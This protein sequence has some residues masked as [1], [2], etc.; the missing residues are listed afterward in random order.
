MKKI[1]IFLTLIFIFTSI[2]HFTSNAQVVNGF[3]PIQELGMPGDE[4]IGSISLSEANLFEKDFNSKYLFPM[5]GI[6][7][8]GNGKIAV[9][10]NSYGR[11]H[12]LNSILENELTFS[13]IKELTYPTDIAFYEGNL[14]ITDPLRNSVAIFNQYGK[15]IKSFGTATFTS[16]I[17]IAVS[18]DGIF[19]SDYFGEKL[20]KL[21]SKYAV[22]KT[23]KIDYPGGLAERNGKIYAV[24]MSKHS[25]YV[26]DKNLNLLSTISNDNMYFPSDV[27]V[28]NA[29]NVYV[30]DRGLLKGKDSSGKVLKFSPN[31]KFLFTIG[32]PAKIYPG[33]KNG[34]LL[35]PCGI[36]VQGENVFVMDG[37]HY[38]WDSNSD[39]PFGSPIGERLSVFSSTSIFLS[40][41]DFSQQTQGRLM[42]PISSTLDKNG[43]IWTVNYG[44]MKDSEIVEF[45]QSGDFIKRIKK[46]G[47]I[48]LSYMDCVYSDKNGHI[49]IGG[50]GFIIVLN[51]SGKLT[52]SINGLKSGEIRKIIKGN[53]GYFYA[54]LFQKN[55]VLQFSMDGTVKKFIPVCNLPSGICES[56][57][58]IFYITSIDDNK[59]HVYND[60][61][62]EIRTI[63][64]GGGRGKMNFYV[65][66]DVAM[67]KYGNII[68]ADAENGRL[69]VFR[70]NGTLL[71]Q[72]PRVFYEIASIEVEDG[73]LVVSDCF[74]NMVRILKENTSEKQ[75]LFLASVYPSS[76][77]VSPGGEADLD[78]NIVN[79]G[80]KSDNYNI[81]I[82]KNISPQWTII[83]EKGSVFLDSDTETKV[84]VIVKAPNNAKN[85]DSITLNITIS[86]PRE[87]ITLNA[88]I[89]VST[90]LPPVISIRSSSV[91]L[92]RE[93]TIP[94]YVNG[95]K[96]ATGITFTMHIPDGLKL[97]N[98]ENGSLINNSLTLSNI[99]GDTAI[100]AIAEKGEQS[101]SG[102]GI[103]A[104]A[105]FKG[106]KI[107]KDVI[108]FTDAYYENIVGGKLNFEIKSGEITIAPYLFVN[109]SDGI[110]NTS[111]NFTF[112]GKTT[113][114]VKL[115][116]N[117][118]TVK[119][120][121]DGTFTST[122][123]LNSLQNV[124]IISARSSSG[125]E[126]VIKRTVFYRGK[127]NI[128]IKLQ[129]GNPTMTVNGV[130]M[131][132]DPGRGTKPFIING[133]NRTVVPI[134]AIIEAIGGDIGWEPKDR[135]VWIIL[136][137][138][139]INMWINN[140][141]AKVN[142][143]PVWIDPSNH[144]VSPIIA[145]NRTFI[146]VRFVA[147]SLGCDVYWDATTKTVTIIYRR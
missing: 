67:D 74:H 118:Q 58:N 57:K 65:P 9:I 38:Y 100:F 11:I 109:F 78:I 79:E 139:T 45:S 34:A 50:D 27:D 14:Y 119:I 72:S 82:E 28:D 124:I 63:G 6:C 25:V 141:Q 23:V 73:I 84:P 36:A 115:T 89:T 20:Y 131:E 60:A 110:A 99:Q 146:P 132:I 18:K 4:F 22:E 105:K 44:G 83:L 96:N 147:E 43:K 136:N 92:G 64:A 8:I 31:G 62:N 69:S 135:M 103:V 122:V 29:G 47:N 75:Y 37:G 53:D 112:T 3:S 86:S 81:F 40:K 145:N 39:A 80:T 85:G 88:K 144:T 121:S 93:I 42:N 1:A 95:L 61:F 51:N 114:G 5:Q 19:I 140:P 91:M 52:K 123:V 130:K 68:V 129:I 33:Q 12:I 133:W 113:I 71:Y 35:T 107:A 94:I 101:I 15:F 66:E 90:K 134:R 56:K 108:E 16:P 102:S 128:T 126:T 48:N 97:E 13:S 30:S 125:E 98:I 24:S 26:Y 76:Q 2:P 143:T 111:Q 120:N 116:V 106:D 70:D 117:G 77:L 41:K 7:G 142:G 87:T 104:V 32:T 10:D 55:S 137:T 127:Q 17:G 49:L 59:V 54:T 21:N 138:T 46:I